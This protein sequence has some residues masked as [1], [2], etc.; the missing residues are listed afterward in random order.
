MTILEP[1]DALDVVRLA[2]RGGDVGKTEAER[3]RAGRV[4]LGGELTRRNGETRLSVA[5]ALS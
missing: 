5:L 1:T 2:E 3:L 4:D